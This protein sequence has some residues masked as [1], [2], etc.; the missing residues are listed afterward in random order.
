[1]YGAFHAMV[2]LFF[3]PGTCMKYYDDELLL[4]FPALPFLCDPTMS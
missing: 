2:L 4:F 1:M 3:F